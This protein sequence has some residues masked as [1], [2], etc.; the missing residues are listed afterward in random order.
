MA[1]APDNG[2]PQPLAAHPQHGQVL[3]TGEG[4]Q[5]GSEPPADRDWETFMS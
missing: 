3:D 4:G 2:I 5:Q 1:L